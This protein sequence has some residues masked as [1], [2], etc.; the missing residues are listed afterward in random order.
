MEKLL[1][2]HSTTGNSSRAVD[3]RLKT[4]FNM[5]IAGPTKAGKSTLVG[6]M[7]NP[8]NGLFDRE[9]D[10]VLI[11][12]GTSS[13]NSNLVED[14]H[15]NY[16]KNC[17]VFDNIFS[18][19][20][21][22]QFPK[23]LD[24]LLENRARDGFHG[25]LI[26]D[27]LMVELGEAGVLVPL[28]T[29]MSSHHQISNLFTTQNLFHHQKRQTDGMTLYRN[30]SYITIFNTPL[31]QTTASIVAQRL[32]GKGFVSTA[33][34][35]KSTY[36]KYRYIFIDGTQCAPSSLQ[37]RTDLTG[38]SEENIPYQRVFVKTKDVFDGDC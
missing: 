26:F 29:K 24:S 33:N 27:D 19:V 16:G 37:F 2:V 14:V 1:K 21:C 36:R 23:F 15:R 11:F 30:A 7:V 8:L 32:D 4:P 6:K 34:M 20:S 38:R 31:D 3:A 13:D 9:F 25:L 28:F 10:Y 18:R 5:I 35:I 22:T 12:T 17:C